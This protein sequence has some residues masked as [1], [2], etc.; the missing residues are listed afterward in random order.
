MWISE[1]HGE[2]ITLGDRVGRGHDV[3]KGNFEDPYMTVVVL[4]DM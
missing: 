3:C 2:V 4:T 1:I